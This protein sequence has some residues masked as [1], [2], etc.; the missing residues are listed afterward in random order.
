MGFL[1]MLL[2]QWNLFSSCFNGNDSRVVGGHVYF[3]LQACGSV[4]HVLFPGSSIGWD[5]LF[6]TTLSI[7][8]NLRNLLS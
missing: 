5:I 6:A 7:T 3:I 2:L 4:E 1:V 8:A